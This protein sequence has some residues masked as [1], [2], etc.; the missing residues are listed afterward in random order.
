[1][2]STQWVYREAEPFYF[3][4]LKGITDLIILCFSKVARPPAPVDTVRDD[5][6]EH[7]RMGSQL[8]LWT[9]VRIEVLIKNEPS[10][11]SNFFFFDNVFPHSHVQRWTVDF[12]PYRRTASF[13]WWA[14]IN[15]ALNIKTSCSSTA[16]QST[17]HWTEMVITRNVCVHLFDISL[18]STTV[19]FPV[20]NFVLFH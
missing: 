12:H 11:V 17:T 20:L 18:T 1:M 2:L 3:M 9:W 6:P 7:R 10:R 5:M 14:Q 13:S 19:N 15:I 16:V 8:H 4:Y